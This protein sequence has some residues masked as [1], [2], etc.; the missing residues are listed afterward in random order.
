VENR[1]DSAPRLW[2]KLRLHISPDTLASRIYRSSTA[3]EA[4]TCNYELNPV[5]RAKLEE[6]GLKVSGIS[7]DGGVR[8]V[9]LPSLRFFLSTGFVP[10]LVSEE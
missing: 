2:G 4:F 3:E 5:Y 9:E 1:P 10:Q 6:S 8:I 7:D